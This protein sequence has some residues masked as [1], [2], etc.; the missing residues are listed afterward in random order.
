M[1]FRSPILG[2]VSKVELGT[3]TIIPKFVRI[4]KG[5]WDKKY[6]FGYY[7]LTGK[8]T[9]GDGK[10]MTASAT[11]WAIPL[12]IVLPAVFALIIF[13]LVIR[14]IKRHYRIVSK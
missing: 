10:I 5:R 8:A 7:E 13:I 11:M 4:F 14:Y 12:V 9:D 3:H 1:L 2:Q 6:P